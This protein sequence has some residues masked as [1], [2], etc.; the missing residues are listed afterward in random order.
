MYTKQEDNQL[1]TR[2]H[3]KP[4]DNEQYLHFHS[5]YP[6]KQKESVPNG[7]LIRSKR[8]C[9]EQKYFDQE[10]RNILQ[11]LRHRKYPPHLLEEAYRKVNS[12][13]RQDLL[14]PS[15]H[16]ENTKLRLITNY[17]PNNPN[18]RAVI[19]KY[20]GLLLI[21]RKSAIRPEDIQV[22]YSRTPNIKDMIIKTEIIKQ[23]TP[24]ISQPCFKPR[25]KICLQMDTTQTIT[26]R[27]NHSYL[28][29]GDFN[30]QSSKIVHVLRRMICGIQYVGESSNTMN[31][32]CRGHSTIRTSKD[33]PVAVH[34]RSYNHTTEDFSITIIDKDQDKN[35]RLRL[36]E[37]WITLL[38]TLTPVKVCCH[39]TE[40]TLN[41]N[42]NDTFCNTAN[43]L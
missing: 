33:H 11:Q 32:S 26:N 31:T 15:M 36:D 13:R 34:Y 12:M 41:L 40:I 25:C 14:G 24:K 8:I 42:R 43:D 30:C 23:Y 18:L 22:T 37:S 2:V 38:D 7:L 20:E 17:N 4:T 28:I 9:S 29:R 6:R 3:H 35:R 19:K 5:A 27:T 1:L 16:E 10:A 39:Y 21:T